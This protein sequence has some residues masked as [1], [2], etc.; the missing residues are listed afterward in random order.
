MLPF[1]FTSQNYKTRNFFIS[2]HLLLLA[3][4]VQLRIFHMALLAS[5]EKGHYFTFGFSWVY[6]ILIA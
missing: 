5:R 3:L 2:S 1:Y 4:F 6:K